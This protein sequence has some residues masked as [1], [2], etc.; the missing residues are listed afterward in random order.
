[1][2]QRPMVKMS[3]CPGHIRVSWEMHLL[4][5]PAHR[6]KSLTK[7]YRDMFHSSVSSFTPPRLKFMSDHPTAAGAP[8]PIDP[9][10]QGGSRPF[11]IHQQ[12]VEKLLEL[13]SV[14]SSDEDDSAT[15]A[16]Q[17]LILDIQEHQ[18]YL[19]RVR[20][21]QWHRQGVE[22]TTKDVPSI[23]SSVPMIVKTD[24]HSSIP[25]T[26]GNTA[27]PLLLG[28]LG[29]GILHVLAGL[30]RHHT[31]FL[32]SILEA[33]VV[34]AV[35]KVTDGLQTFGGHH[36][37]KDE[38]NSLTSGWP[39]D[40]RSALGLLHVDPELRQY[41]C[42][43]TCFSLYGPFPEHQTGDY[44]NIPMDCSHRAT[45][46]SKPCGSQLFGKH[47]SPSHCFWYQ[48]LHSWIARFLS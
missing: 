46:S 13:V 39:K 4:L 34:A 12:Y 6:W 47:G 15:I 27:L 30:S 42:C 3:Y 37:I 26:I 9:S 45:P 5:F 36:R 1:M 14:V 32:L 40:I 17:R 43:P 20:D 48:P 38:I 41:I 22:T 8:P 11:I 33:V 25:D 16:R 21:Y 7:Q 2:H 44:Q 23:G 28:I 29:A 19:E 35:G 31:N 10:D 24:H 18:G